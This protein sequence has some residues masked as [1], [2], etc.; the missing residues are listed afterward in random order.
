LET[1]RCCCRR[2]GSGSRSKVLGRNGREGGSER[3]EFCI[4]LAGL[5]AGNGIRRIRRPTRI[6]LDKRCRRTDSQEP[7]MGLEDASGGRTLMSKSCPACAGRGVRHVPLAGGTGVLRETCPACGGTGSPPGSNLLSPE[8]G[9]EWRRAVGGAG[10]ILLVTLA[11][12]L[13]RLTGPGK[14]APGP[15]PLPSRHRSLDD[16]L[17]STIQRQKRNSLSIWGARLAGMAAVPADQSSSFR[18]AAFIVSTLK[19]VPKPVN[20][21]K[22]QSMNLEGSVVAPVP[23]GD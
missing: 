6:V 9:T 3:G 14:E 17:R 5:L 18:I 19:P 21:A 15:P 8:P 2:R 4:N 16:F 1:A 7:N 11:L 23:A 10:L 20:A 22:Q 12:A 13:P